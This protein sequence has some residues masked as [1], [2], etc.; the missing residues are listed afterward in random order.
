MILQSLYQLFLRLSANPENGLAKP[1]HSLQ[2]VS[3]KIVLNQDGTVV[4]FYDIR[5]EEVTIGKNGKEKRRL[6]PV[7]L[8][9]PGQTKPSGQGINPCTLWDNSTYLAGYPQPD[10]N[11]E[12][13]AKNIVRAL[14]C[15]EV[16]KKLHIEMFG[17]SSEPTLLA[18]ARYFEKHTPEDLRPFVE[19][20]PED[21]RRG[22]GV[23]QLTGVPRYAHEVYDLPMDTGEQASSEVLGQCLVTGELAPI[24]R[25]HEPKIKTFD[26]KG[27]LLVSFNEVA[28]ESY[29]K[30]GKDSGQG[31]NSP[32]SEQVV[33]GYCNALNWLLSHPER[34]FRL[35]DTT[36]VFWTAKPTRIETDFPWM[37]EGVPEAEDSETKDRVANLLSKIA[38]GILGRDELEDPNIEFYILGLAPNASRLSVRFWHTGSLGDLMANLKLHLTQIEI[39]RQW[40]KTEPLHPS[41]YQLLRQTARDVDGIPP[42]LGG[43]LMR[44]I[45]LG[46]R[47]PEAL[48]QGVLRRIRVVEKKAKGEG[49]LDN[50]NYFR[51]AILKGWLLRNHQE[52]L[53]Q[54][55]IIM[56]TALDKEN[57]STAYQLGRLF[58]VYEQAQRAAHDFNLDRT[59]RETMFSSASANPLSVFG[60]LDRLNKHH[61]RKLTPQSNRFFSNIID[62]IHQKIKSP[63]FYPASLNPKEQSLFCIGY[64]HQRHDMKPGKEKKS[65]TETITT[66]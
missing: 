54:N 17:A 28:Y 1:G 45:L 30:T 31:R 9:V 50:V 49:I 4:G 58:A 61:L 3:F 44:A 18:V 13:A 62:E 51:V 42:L 8:Q 48:A 53:T 34:R 60:R 26:P 5:R 64:Y 38:R 47:Y 12:K 15:F 39:V 16:G 2:N 27:S 36:A 19:Q 66:D 35:G 57:P 37:L 40:D 41:A 14:K 11:P 25:L 21:I 22:N 43:A 32:V 59:I 23:F 56:T 55:N 24:A 7:E 52:W 20:L 63:T 6:L 10:T 46:T 29:G 65:E 33:F